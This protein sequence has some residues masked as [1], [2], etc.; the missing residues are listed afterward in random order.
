MVDVATI[1]TTAVDPV[2]QCMA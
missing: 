1:M 2:A